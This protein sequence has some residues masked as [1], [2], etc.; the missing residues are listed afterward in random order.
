MAWSLILHPSYMVWYT[1]ESLSLSLS[2]LCLRI[3]L[4]VPYAD[5]A[6][7]V[8]VGDGCFAQLTFEIQIEGEI[9]VTLQ[10][11]RKGRRREACQRKQR[12]VEK[13]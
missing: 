13:K 12:Q 3:V 2:L 1:G 7:L 8:V 11:G 6:H 10:A 4:N 5:L 9:Q